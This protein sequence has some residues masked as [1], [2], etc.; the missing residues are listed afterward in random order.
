MT[1]DLDRGRWTRIATIF[2]RALD[3][4]VADR[5]DVLGQLCGSDETIRREVED[6]L[7]AHDRSP[8]LI[9]ERRLVTGDDVERD[10]GTL[11]AGTRIGPY[12]I[13]SLVGAGGMGDV[14]RAE[15]A[16]GAHHQ[17]VALKVLRPGFRT[18]DMV[19][20]FR[21]EREAL[22]RLVHPGIATILD[23]GSLEDGRPYIVLQ[24]VDGL[25][26]TTY[27]SAHQLSVR[28]RL[29]LFL[30][31]VSAVQF[32]HG[33][34]VI[35]RDLKPSNILVDEA[36]TPRLLDF[37]IAKLLDVR[38]DASLGAATAADVRLFTPEYAAPEQ[39]RGEPPTT[40]TDVYA[41]G[42]LLFE[43]LT[44]TRPFRTASGSVSR[45]ERAVL[46]T[47]APAPSSVV[48][49][50][51]DARR[52]RGD[53]DRIV[54]MALRKEPERR[55]D[56]A[57][58]FGEDIER[59]LT[60]QPVVASANSVGYRLR[61]F[62]QRN[63]ALAAAGAIVALLVSG[64]AVTSTL[65]ARRVARER[66]RAE[67]ERTSAEDVLRILTGLF[68][69]GNPN[70]HPG[71]DTLRVTSLLD[72]AEHDVATMK[73]D[74]VRQA[75][76][77]RTVGRMRLAR[78]EYARGI[79]LLTR[80]YDQR[81]KAFGSDDLEAARLHHEMAVALVSYRG[82]LASQPMLDSSLDELRRLLGDTHDE[83]RQAMRDLL[84]VTFDSVAARP[85]LDRLMR[86]ER[87]SPSTDPIALAEQLNRR[88]SERLEAK[89]YGEAVAL[90]QATVDIVK[91]QLP[92]E[93][94]DVRTV[95]RNLAVALYMAGRLAEAESLQRAELALET[96]LN[97][98]SLSNGMAR[99][100]LALTYFAERR[101]DSAEAEERAALDAFRAGAA[102][103]HWRIWSAQRNLA[104]MMAAHGRVAAGLALLDSAIVVAGAGRDS[105]TE[106]GYLT[107][108]RVPFLLRLGRADEASAAIA[109]SERMLGAS[110]AVSTAH[111]ADVDRYAGM[112]ALAQGDAA[113]AAERFRGAVMLVEPPEKPETIPDINSCLL[114]VSLARL[115]RFGEAQPLLDKPCAR[116]TSRGVPDP[117]IVGWIS[118]AARRSR[119]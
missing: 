81:R 77:W 104:I 62:V 3:A 111:R 89:R 37:G 47:P 5:A 36:G 92:P 64:F 20:R 95:E 17:T 21:I 102:P 25:P 19:R 79:E 29:T 113:R 73:N 63:R 18:A 109:T 52:L 78:G 74:V 44:G 84:M 6:M 101:A 11:P 105:S 50:H 94:E 108:Q 23:G 24:F 114:G 85:L 4:S 80:A 16:D 83:V 15:R 68:E 34:L 119:R 41:L 66:D 58:Q 99:E 40:A 30:R 103:V 53:L 54:L 56:S 32:A 38:D 35:H 61:K 76:L 97:G 26:F 60:G 82:E 87:E 42:V 100:A 90:F 110:P 93:H 72:S 98:S 10:A 22:A 46:D 67:R 86:L 71:G 1:T 14:Y 45:V 59:Y 9:A 7:D 48:A 12:R 8:G 49:S 55:Y 69:R 112:V 28:E 70:T 96:R 75:T 39:F 106:T 31:I 27:C 43:L 107:A 91:R 88:G 13:E 118:D 51:T 65:Q 116:Y 2:D 57:G 117:M 115:G 33:R